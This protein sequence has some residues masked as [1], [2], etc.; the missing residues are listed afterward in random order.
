M[1]SNTPA[2]AL[3]HVSLGTNDFARAIDFYD[4]LM[5]TIGCFRIVDRD[6]ARAYGRGHPEFWIQVPHDGEAATVGNGSHVSFLAVSRGD[7]DLFHATG[8]ANGA[9]DAGRPGPRPEYGEGYYASSLRDP[10]GH[11]I[12]AMYF[13]ADA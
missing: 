11:K 6:G 13:D 12:E 9:A 1:T 7:V 4:A 2:T 8:L 5:P 3:S 10:D